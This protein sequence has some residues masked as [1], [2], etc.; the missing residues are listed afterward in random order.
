MQTGAPPPRGEDYQPSAAA[1]EPESGAPRTEAPPPWTEVKQQ[2]TPIEL[3]AVRR[4]IA[5]EESPWH[6]VIRQ[7]ELAHLMWWVVGLTVFAAA[8]LAR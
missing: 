6:K 8:C 1:S 3:A 5:R 4:I 7:I 2:L